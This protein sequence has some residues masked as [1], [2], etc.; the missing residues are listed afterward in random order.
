MKVLV[1]FELLREPTGFQ[2]LFSESATGSVYRAAGEKTSTD[3]DLMDTREIHWTGQG[4]VEL[5]FCRRTN[6]MCSSYF[7]EW[8]TAARAPMDRTPV[9]DQW[10][11]SAHYTSTQTGQQERTWCVD[12]DRRREYRLKSSSGVRN[13]AGDS[14]LIVNTCSFCRLHVVNW[15]HAPGNQHFA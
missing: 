15:H 14:D 11:S 10:P 9:H 4:P 1:N 7:Q 6:I 5:S 12:R 13:A 8:Q 2:S 3:I